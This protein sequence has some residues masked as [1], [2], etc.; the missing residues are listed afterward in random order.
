MVIVNSQ[1]QVLYHEFSKQEQLVALEDEKRTLEARKKLREEGVIGSTRDAIDGAASAVGSGVGAGAEVVGSGISA[2]VGVVGSGMGA[3]S[4]GL[5]KA[6]KFVGRTFTGHSISIHS[7]SHRREYS[8]ALN[9]V[10][11]GGSG[12]GGDAKPV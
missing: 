5:S 1:R 2:G 10:H 9:S 7:K 6:G 3:V 4:S 11:E 8:P 12:G